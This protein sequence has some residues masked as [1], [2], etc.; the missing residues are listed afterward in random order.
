[1]LLAIYS[2]HSCDIASTLFRLR[3][4]FIKTKIRYDTNP[5]RTHTYRIRRIYRV[6]KEHIANPGRDL[7]RRAKFSFAHR[8][9]YSTIRVSYMIILH[10][11]GKKVNY[12]IAFFPL[13][14]GF[15]CHYNIL[16]S[17]L[18]KTQMTERIPP[19]GHFLWKKV[20]PALFVIV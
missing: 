13:F 6:P 10:P 2:F 5:S 17:R 19:F 18:F 3:Y 11:L 16:Y 9:L 4:I 12:K 8:G 20:S 7:Y 1:M 15:F 14:F